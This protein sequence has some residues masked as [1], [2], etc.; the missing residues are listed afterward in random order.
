MPAPI[1][2]AKPEDANAITEILGS[3]CWFEHIDADP[4]GHQQ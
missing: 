4:A 2:K 3:L 1:H